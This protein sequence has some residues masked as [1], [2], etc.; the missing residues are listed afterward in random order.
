MT[1]RGLVGWAALLGVSAVVHLLLSSGA[2][3]RIDAGVGRIRD[4]TRE[5]HLA[6]AVQAAVEEKP[7]EPE[8][9]HPDP[10]EFEAELELEPPEVLVVPRAVAPPPPDV[11]TALTAASGGPAG[12]MDT[13]TGASG[14]VLPSALPGLAGSGADSASAGGGRAEAGAG[15]GAG[16]TGRGRGIGNGLGGS[17]N[18]FAAYVAGLRDAGLD[19]VF[20]VD[21]TGSMDWV[22]NEVKAR[23]EDIV[24]TVR[25]LVPI[26]RFGVVAYRDA[27]DPE[28][29][30]RTQPLTYSASKLGAFLGGLDARGG[31]S[32]QE[33]IGAGLHEAIDASGW[34]ASA[35]R[36]VIVIGDAPPRRDEIDRL[37]NLARQFALAARSPRSTS[38]RRRTRR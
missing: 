2:S 14:I 5:I 16:G 12:A 9:E 17:G 27:G 26:A 8:A 33:D 36:L 18:R 6:V 30:T 22:L 24:D 34:R 7:A 21:A 13:S 29:V 37:R 32:L 1:V 11:K 19:V 23:I 15:T 25:A 20:V 28:F 3:R 38:V 10:L 31:G 4:A 35:K